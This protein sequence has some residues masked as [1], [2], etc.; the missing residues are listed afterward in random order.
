MSVMVAIFA[1]VSAVSALEP[2]L[3][4]ET[5]MFLKEHPL[6]EIIPIPLET[7]LNLILTR[8]VS[9][10]SYEVFKFRIRLE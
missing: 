6:S 1:L 8:Y 5:R 10:E 4:P 3:V 2:K 9:E 7:I